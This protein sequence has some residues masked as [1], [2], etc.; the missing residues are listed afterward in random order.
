METLLIDSFR[1]PKIIKEIFKQIRKEA[2]ELKK[3]LEIMEVCGG[4]THTIMKYAFL[5]L[6]PENINFIHGPGCPVCIMPKNRIDCA[7]SIAQSNKEVILVTLGDMIKVPG[8]FGSLQNARS[9]GLSVDFVYSPLD[10]LKIAQSNPNKQVVFFAI[11]FETT[12]PMSAALLQKAMQLKLKNLSLFSNHVLVPPPLEAILSDKQCVI[13]AIL[14]PSHVSVIT[15]AK[16]YKP[17]LDKFSLPIVVGGFEPVDI[18]RSILMLI[19]QAKAMQSGAYPKLEIEYARS[20]SYEGNVH[21][22]KLVERFFEIA[23]SFTWRGL[24]EIAHSSLQI[25]EEFESFDASKIFKEYLPQNPAK[26]H[27]QCLCGNILKGK[28][29]P[30]DCKLFATTCTP[31]NPLGSCMVS[32][33]GACAAYFKYHHKNTLRKTS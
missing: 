20:V 9:M 27:K 3:P 28:N 13:N 14:A 16:I 11:G 2:Q 31:Q 32:S 29:K 5:D 1:N 4:H 12:T 25:K 24:G 8:T 30:L 7:H 18:A 17:L 22:Q 23:P 10:T 21:A 33:E 15:G 6:L 26:E 19:L